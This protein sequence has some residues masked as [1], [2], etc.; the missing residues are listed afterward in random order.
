MGND[1]DGQEKKMLGVSLVMTAAERDALDDWVHE[2]R[3]K[4]VGA[5]IRCMVR[6]ALARGVKPDDEPDL[7]RKRDGGKK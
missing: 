7:R 5:A 6:F 1:I 4:S 2:H 3:V